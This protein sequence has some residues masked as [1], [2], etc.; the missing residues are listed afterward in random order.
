MNETYTLLIK[1]LLANAQ[2]KIR[3]IN[4]LTNCIQKSNAKESK[5]IAYLM[6]RICEEDITL[7]ILRE[8]QGWQLQSNKDF[9]M[10][11]LA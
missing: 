2:E 9:F 1:T 11:V 3:L 7:D 5:E 4:K 10:S 6:H 8:V